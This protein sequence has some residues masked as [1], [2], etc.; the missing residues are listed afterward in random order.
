M[1]GWQFH[2]DVAHKNLYIY[3][4]LNINN[5]YT[6]LSPMPHCI[7]Y[8]IQ[9]R[10]PW[11]WNWH[12]I[13][14]CMLIRFKFREDHIEWQSNKIYPNNEKITNSFVNYAKNAIFALCTVHLNRKECI[15][16][17][18]IFWYH[19]SK[20]LV[21]FGI[22]IQR[23]GRMWL[24]IALIKFVH[25]GFGTSRCIDLAHFIEGLIF[26]GL[27]LPTGLWTS[28]HAILDG[29]S[30]QLKVM[31]DA[32]HISAI[33]FVLHIHKAVDFIPLIQLIQRPFSNNIFPPFLIDLNT[34]NIQHVFHFPSHC[35]AQNGFVYK[36]PYGHIII[37]GINIILGVWTLSKIPCI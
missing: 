5:L 6:D 17:L 18:D 19:V 37:G 11:V 28:T 33:K 8:F 30:W 23:Y 36:Y 35:V 24:E 1:H 20:K 14:D 12:P 13:I 15:T 10:T 25:K 4:N 22:A 3:E 34:L 21:S 29:K 9:L 27:G 26:F 32:L 31:E 16:I 7:T 2:H